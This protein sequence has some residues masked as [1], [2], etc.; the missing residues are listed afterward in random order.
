ML[1]HLACYGVLSSFVGMTT[2]SRSPLSFVRHDYFR[3]ILCDW[4]ASMA[5][6]A[7]SCADE[8]QLADLVRRICYE[9]AAKTV[10]DAK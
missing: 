5:E 6:G 7:W 8:E 10:F 9:N 1:E 4:I 3:R 2:D